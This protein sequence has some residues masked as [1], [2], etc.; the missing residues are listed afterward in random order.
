MEIL[1]TFLTSAEALTVTAFNWP[2]TNI[3]MVELSITQLKTLKG[4]KELFA[5]FDSF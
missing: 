2:K 4:L 5:S 1:N 3:S